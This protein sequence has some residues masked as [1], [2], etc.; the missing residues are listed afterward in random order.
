MGVST[1]CTRTL[2]FRWDFMS[3]SMVAEPVKA[4]VKRLRAH[5]VNAYICIR[6]PKSSG[7]SQPGWLVRL[8]QRILPAANPDLERFFDQVVTWHVEIKAATGEPSR[9]V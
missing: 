6:M 1:P 8:L 9:E 2:R 7:S 4:T 3:R 5:L